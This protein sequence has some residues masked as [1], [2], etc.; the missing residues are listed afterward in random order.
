MNSTQCNNINRREA[1]KCAVSLLG[2]TIIGAEAFLSGCTSK[3]KGS[4]FLSE[5]D[6]LLLDEIGETILPESNRS[7]GAK[8]AQIG[9]FMKTI[10][11]DCY[12]EKDQNIFETG[13]EEL[14]RSAQDTYGKT[15]M[16]IS[17]S[18]RFELLAGFDRVAREQNND[19]EPHFFTM[20]KQLTVLGYFTSEAG[21]TQ[22]M[23]YDPVPGSY[24]GCVEYKSG[25]KAW[26]GPL[27]SIG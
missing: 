17:S 26:F 19:V 16:T 23:R 8:A 15:F 18:E 5:E 12:S 7:P 9:S 25:D 6:I 20:M 2:G 13:L 11:S 3:N 14:R 24:D 22:A 27:S 10:I 1:L 21:V 4:T